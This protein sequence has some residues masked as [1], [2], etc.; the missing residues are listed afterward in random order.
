PPPQ[1]VTRKLYLREEN[2]LSFERPASSA[3]E[4]FDTYVSDPKKPV[5]FSTE[6][7]TTQGHLWMIEDQRFASTR[8]DVLVYES[9]VLTEDVTIAGP[10]IAHLQVSTTGTDSDFVVKLIDVLPGDFPDNEPN[11]TGTR[12][13]HFQM[14]LAGEVFRAKFRKSFETPEP[15]VPGEVTP[16]EFDLRDRNHTF[17]KG[18]RIMVQIQSSWFPV[19]DR[20]PQTFVDIY[21]AQE[22]DFRPATQTVYR[23]NERPSYLE[24]GVIEKSSRES[25][26]RK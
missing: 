22:S 8:P 24:V 2:S 20:N 12:M 5:P 6:T 4:A 16:I 1:A 7:R 11:P 19:I 9:D 18:H 17:E 3:N 10:I 13:G 26:Q 23:S 14:L 15:M 21:H 25:G